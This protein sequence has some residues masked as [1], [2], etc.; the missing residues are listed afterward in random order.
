MDF[1]IEAA[2]DGRP[3]SEHSL[4]I[5]MPAGSA[6]AGRVMEVFPGTLEGRAALVTVSLALGPWGMERARKLIAQA[7][8]M[9]QARQ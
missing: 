8:K 4:V 3:R 9:K 6:L 1:M 5:T 2:A 7:E